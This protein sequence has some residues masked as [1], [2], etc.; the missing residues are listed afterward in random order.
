VSPAPRDAWS[1]ASFVSVAG[2][3]L[4]VLR[5]GESS[6]DAPTLVFLHEGLGSASLWREFPVRVG[7]ASG[8]AVVAYSRAGYGRSETIAL[9]RP[10][11][12][13]HEEGERV[14]P[15]L[16][17]A[18]GIA[19]AI[20]IGHSDGASIALIHAGRVDAGRAAGRR[21]RIEGLVLEAPHVF[22]ED[23]SVASIAK[24]KEA[25]E[26]GDL[27]ARLAKHHDDVDAAFFGWNRA[28]LDPQFRAWNLEAYLPRIQAPVLV[29]QGEQDPYGTLAQV[30]AIERG[31]PR[32]AGAGDSAK[33]E[34]VI[35]AA[36]GHAPHREQPAKTLASIVDWLARH[37]TPG[38]RS[39]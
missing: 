11:S 32:A 33:V 4:E 12:Y 36:C 1:D 21:G 38:T 19:R 23:L 28:W 30:E 34:R 5:H 31:V 24:A 9:P 22:C 6:A 17:D 10:L 16:L 18:L 7:D 20:L 29:V 8:L 39:G 37:V 27:R 25:Y 15:E 35:L 14:L 26:R 13:M 2:K 3:R